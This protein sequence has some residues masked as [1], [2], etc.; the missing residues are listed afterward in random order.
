MRKI[1]DEFTFMYDKKAI[2][3]KKIGEVHCAIFGKTAVPLLIEF[4]KAEQV[5][6]GTIKKLEGGKHLSWLP[7]E[8]IE[9]IT[10]LQL[11]QSIKNLLNST[12][13]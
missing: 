5:P 4:N 10:E 6:N 2:Q 11:L 12:D 7:N 3:V 8:A 1:K 13:L 9:E